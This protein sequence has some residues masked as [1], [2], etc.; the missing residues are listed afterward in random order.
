MQG[1]VLDTPGKQPVKLYLISGVGVVGLILILVGTFFW[2][3]QPKTSDLPVMVTPLVASPSAAAVLGQETETL[4]ENPLDES[5]RQITDPE[6]LYTIEIPKS[7]QIISRASR[8][9]V[10]LSFLTVQSSDFSFHTDD[11][12]EGPFEP[13]YYDTGASLTMHVTKGDEGSKHTGDVLE[14]KKFFIDQQPASY[15]RF[16]EPNTF[17][18]EIIDVN[19][20]YNGNNYLLRMGYNPDT[21]PHGI[22]IFNQIVSSFSFIQ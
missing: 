14:I 6:N 20:N 21:Y 3:Q 16:I 10:Q 8:E 15:T 5:T 7:W 22:D 17:N 18:G 13:I 2:Q 11:N 4:P 12:F 19:V 9:G 1:D